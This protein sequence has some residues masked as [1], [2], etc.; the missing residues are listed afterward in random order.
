M[1]VKEFECHGCNSTFVMREEEMPSNESPIVCPRCKSSDIER[2]YFPDGA[3]RLYNLVK[4]NPQ[5]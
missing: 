2:Y 4:P 1:P 5:D 3:C